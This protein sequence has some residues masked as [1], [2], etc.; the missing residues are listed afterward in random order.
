MVEL[1]HFDRRAAASG[2][3]EKGDGLGVKVEVILKK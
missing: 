2:F 3:P 1:Y